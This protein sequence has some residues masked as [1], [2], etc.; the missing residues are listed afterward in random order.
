M[1]CQSLEPFH[2]E[3]LLDTSEWGLILF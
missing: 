3:L 1:I 2:Y